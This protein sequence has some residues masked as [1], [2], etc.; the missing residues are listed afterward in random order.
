[1]TDH[2]DTIRRL[3][4]LW[5]VGG[6]QGERVLSELAAME[7]ERQQAQELNETF[8]H[9]RRV[10]IDKRRKALRQVAE[11]KAER[12]QAID[13]LREIAYGP[14]TGSTWDG[15]NGWR[16]AIKMARAALV[17]LGEKP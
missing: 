13:A 17:K 7:A 15:E 16:Q 12:Q 5:H 9:D 11:L 2:A 4:P 14:P 8:R 1:M 10:L 3:L 6:T